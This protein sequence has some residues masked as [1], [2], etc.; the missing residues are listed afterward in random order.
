MDALLTN[1]GK[2]LRVGQQL[3]ITLIKGSGMIECK[4]PIQPLA[5]PE[6]FPLVAKFSE[7]VVKPDFR[8]FKRFYQQDI[9][10]QKVYYLSNN[11]SGIN[12]SRIVGISAILHSFS[13]HFYFQI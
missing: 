1:Q 13:L 9:P 6:Y 3:R 10:S 7:S 8:K 5:P 12:L 11:S 2:S 4:D